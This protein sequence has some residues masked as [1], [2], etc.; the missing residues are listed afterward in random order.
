M[1]PEE[2][3]YNASH[4]WVG[5]IEEGGNKI[6]VVGI[7]DFALELLTDLVYMALP[8]V[9]EPADAKGKFVREAC[10]SRRLLDG[11]RQRLVKEAL[12]VG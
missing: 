6:A 8:Q 7:T 2:L 4:E 5:V 1:K 11:K 3:K 12:G 9:G 10:L